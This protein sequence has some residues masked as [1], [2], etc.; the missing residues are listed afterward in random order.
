MPSLS[1]IIID[2]LISPIA[3][4]ESSGYGVSSGVDKAPTSRPAPSNRNDKNASTTGFVPRQSYKAKPATT[5]KPTTTRF[6]PRTVYTTKPAT[7]TK[8]TTAVS[9]KRKTLADFMAEAKK[10]GKTGK[11]VSN[12]AYTMLKDSKMRTGTTALTGAR[13]SG[14]KKEGA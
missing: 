10:K 9:S 8:P 3:A 4:I 2:S 12:Y 7:T 13:I 1:R 11:A 14:T 5:T 6:I